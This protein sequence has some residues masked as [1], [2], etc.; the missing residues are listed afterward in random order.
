MASDLMRKLWM[1]SI[2]CCVNTMVIAFD[3]FVHST[4]TFAAAP[5]WPLEIMFNTNTS[6]ANRFVKK[7]WDPRCN[8]SPEIWD[9]MET[10]R[11]AALCKKHCHSFPSAAPVIPSMPHSWQAPVQASFAPTLGMEH[12]NQASV[13]SVP[14]PWNG[15]RVPTMPNQLIPLLATYPFYQYVRQSWLTSAM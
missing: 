1:R 9:R 6:T 3:C 7:H 11:I 14:G 12:P 8:V 5:Q 2:R 13:S 10:N 15:W 4:L